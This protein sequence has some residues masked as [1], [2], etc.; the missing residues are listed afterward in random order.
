MGMLWDNRGPGEFRHKVTTIEGDYPEDRPYP[1]IPA[2]VRKRVGALLREVADTA[3]LTALVDFPDEVRRDADLIDPPATR[4]SPKNGIPIYRM[5][6]GS[7]EPA[8]TVDAPDDSHDDHN[9]HGAPIDSGP[10]LV[11]LALDDTVDDSVPSDT[12]AVYDPMLG[13]SQE[14]PLVNPITNPDDDAPTENDWEDMPG[15]IRNTHPTVTG[16]APLHLSDDDIDTVVLALTEALGS[17]GTDS[18]DSRG[19]LRAFAYILDHGKSDAERPTVID[20]VE[21]DNGTAQEAIRL[22]TLARR[23]EESI[24]SEKARATATRQLARRAA[25]GLLA[26]GSD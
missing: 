5:G 21:G 8:Y 26:Q 9:R 7:D 18:W 23:Q 4:R 20:W 14:E 16:G 17:L 6:D 3:G 19:V 10:P 1:P 11:G 22:A 13:E 25:G 2:E 24:A 15:V 12:Y